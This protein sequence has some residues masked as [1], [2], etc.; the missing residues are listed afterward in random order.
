VLQ[1]TDAEGLKTL[2]RETGDPPRTTVVL[3][4]ARVNE[5]TA[6]ALALGNSYRAD[7]FEAVTVMSDPAALQLLRRNWTALGVEVPLRVVSSHQAEF[8]QAAAQYVRSLDPGPDHTVIVIIPELV[9][10]HW[11]ESFFH[12]QRALRLRA[13][14]HRIPWV[15]VMNVA[16]HLG[17]TPRPEIPD[18]GHSTREN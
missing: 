14:L 8:G 17:A 10:K 6:R 16:L 18:H 2:I 1:S 5:L 4:V 7:R 11:Y 13:A 12:N 3:F 15:V 9:V